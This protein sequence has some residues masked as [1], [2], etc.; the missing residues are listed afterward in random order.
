MDNITQDITLHILGLGPLTSEFFY[1]TISPNVSHQPAAQPT[2]C[3][4]KRFSYSL[5]K[6][7]NLNGAM[8][9][10]VSPG[11]SVIDQPRS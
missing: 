8:V 10:L 11:W 5:G 7:H 3:H 4:F 1:L 2:V 6:H 9:L